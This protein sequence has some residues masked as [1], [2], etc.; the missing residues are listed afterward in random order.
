LN[1][2]TNYEKF[3]ELD[4]FIVSPSTAT[5]SLLDH[6]VRSPSAVSL[7]LGY[8]ENQDIIDI[9]IEDPKLEGLTLKELNLPPDVL[10]LAITRENKMIMVHGAVHLK[11]KDILTVSGSIDSLEVVATYLGNYCMLKQSS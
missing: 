7:L 11:L 5:I 9:E 3:R 1:D 8:E 2:R 10:I 4:A 6:Y